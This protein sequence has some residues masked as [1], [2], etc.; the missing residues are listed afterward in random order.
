M[1]PRCPSLSEYRCVWPCDGRTS[2][3]GGGPAL[4]PELPGEDAV[5]GDPE[6][7]SRPEK[8]DLTCFFASF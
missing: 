1:C 8:N 5:T 4:C 6:L 2:C 7:V 3:P